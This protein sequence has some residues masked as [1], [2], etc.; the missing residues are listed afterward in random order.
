MGWGW[1][2]GGGG[3][4]EGNPENIWVGVCRWNFEDTPIHKFPD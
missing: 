1:E 2:A 3:G 4:G